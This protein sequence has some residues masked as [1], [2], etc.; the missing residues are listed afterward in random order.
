MH[1]RPILRSN[2]AIP[3]AYRR[4]FVHLYLDIAWYGVLAASAASF[5]TVYAARQGASA[6]QIGLFSAGPAVMNLAFTLPAGRWLEGQ[7]MDAAVSWAAIFHRMFYLLWVPLPLLLG[8]QGQIWALVGMTLLMSIPGTALAVGFN[9]LFAE[10]VP[11]EWRGHVAGVRNALLAMTFIAVSLLCGYI[12]D[13]VPFPLG[14]QVVFGIGFVG[15]AMST[16]HLWFVVPR[17]DGQPRQRVGRGLGDL[18]WPGRF[19]FLP[20]SLRPAVALRFVARGRP[21]AVRTR[22][23]EIVRSPFGRLL[24]VLFAFHVSV[25]LAVPLFPLHWVNNLGLGDQEIGYGTAIFY[26]SVFVSSTQLERLVRR[27][28]NQQVTAVGAM[29]MA[30]Y[31]TFMAL[32]HGLGLFLVG[33]AAGGLGWSLVS[34]A[35]TNYLLDKIPAD[36]RPAYLAWYNLALNAALLLGSLTGPLLSNLIGLPAALLLFAG[37]RV[38]TAAGILL[39]E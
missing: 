13:A 23:P 3:E 20:D 9:A 6:F 18:A 10:A 34:G 26:V 24:A 14:Y 15:A 25:H 12:L 28:G 22:L 35:L 30:L 38:L 32:A 37:L 2:R 29:I 21:R 16:L 31:P 4:N 39:W 1:V 17:P 7:A 33:S 11:P 8:S 5:V 19:R 27:L 36:R